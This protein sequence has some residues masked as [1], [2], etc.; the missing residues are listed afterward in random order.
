MSLT[1]NTSMIANDV[2]EIYEFEKK[3]SA[4]RIKNLFFHFSGFFSLS[5]IG[6]LLNNEHDKMKQFVQPLVI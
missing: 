4:V 6:L 2:R 3:I 1:N 5:F